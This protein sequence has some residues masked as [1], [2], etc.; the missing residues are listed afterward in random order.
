MF[1]GV[2][3]AAKKGSP[4][5]STKQAKR[6]ARGGSSDL[7]VLEE[8]SKTHDGDRILFKDVS[9]TIRAGDK[10]AVAGA[11]GAGKTTL[12]RLLT[13]EAVEGLNADCSSMHAVV[14][15]G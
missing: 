1:A 15:H 5:K 9:F 7:L 13:G 14:Q 6:P 2:V 10:L 4:G 8:V 12:L 11:N 3:K